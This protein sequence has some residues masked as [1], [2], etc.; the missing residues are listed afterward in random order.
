MEMTFSYD[1]I[2]LKSQV[3]ASTVNWPVELTEEQCD[4]VKK[5]ASTGKYKTI[6]EDPNLRDV[7]SKVYDEAMAIEMSQDYS[8]LLGKAYLPD[9]FRYPEEVKND[10]K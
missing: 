3:I 8:S 10:N 4:R 5:S 1:C 6:D 2:A 7:F 9:N